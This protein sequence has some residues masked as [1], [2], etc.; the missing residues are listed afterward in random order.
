MNNRALLL[1]VLVFLAGL[2]CGCLIPASPGSQPTPSPA[3]T[4]AAPLTIQINATPSRYNPAMS[5]T[6][7]IRLTPVNISGITPP[8]SQFTW[9]T[10]FG[11][12][13]HWGP[14]DFRVTGL[15]SSYTGTAEPIYWSFFSDMNSK[16]RPPVMVTLTVS[17]SSTQKILANASMRLV[18]A[19][20]NGLTAIVEAYG[21]SCLQGS[22]HVAFSP[23]LILPLASEG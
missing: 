1:I 12:F 15:G 8:D 20:P 4:V 6:V 23:S 11:S 7:G 5:S 9:A 21:M 18:W 16:E 13:Y 2:A 3:P 17:D 14:P 19:D 22:L 10:T